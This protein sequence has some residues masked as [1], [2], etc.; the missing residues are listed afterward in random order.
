ML[1]IT[2][3]IKDLLYKFSK[4]HTL[5]IGYLKNQLKRCAE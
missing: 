3:K 2:E 4:I 1:F 5:K